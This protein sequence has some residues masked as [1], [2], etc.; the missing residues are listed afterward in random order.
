MIAVIFKVILFS[1]L[2]S[3]V[4]AVVFIVIFCCDL[5][6]FMMALVKDFML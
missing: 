3:A 5:Q 4:I 1:L 2:F 6:K